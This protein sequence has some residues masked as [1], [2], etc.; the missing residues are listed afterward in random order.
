MSS[1][2][3]GGNVAVRFLLAHGEKLWMAGIAISAGLLIWSAI[4]HERLD[5]NSTPEDLQALVSSANTHIQKFRWDQAPEEKK[6]LASAVS[7]EAMKPIPP[8]Q[9]P[10]L[11]QK[12][13]PR[14]LAPVQQRTD[15]ELLPAIDLEAYGD[16]G[17][18]ATSTPESIAAK[19]R[20]EALEA[21][22][23]EKEN[24]RKRDDPLFS[25][26]SPAAAGR[27][28]VSGKEGVIIERP[29][30]GSQLQGYEDTKAESWVTVVA[31]IPIK[32]Q[33]LRYQNALANARGYVQAQDVPRYLGYYVQRS[34]VTNAGEGPWTT[35]AKVGDKTIQNELMKSA[36][37]TPSLINQKYI[38]P[39]LTYPLP[40]LLLR[41]WDKRITHSEIPLLIDEA[42]EDFDAES[43]AEDEM[44]SAD[45]DDP[46]GSPAFRPTRQR[47]SARGA[48]PSRP[49][50]RPMPGGEYRSEAG[51]Y[52]AEP[53]MGGGS[54]RG[55]R[56]RSVPSGRGS[57]ATGG[58]DD[59]DWDGTTQYLLF[60]YIDRSVEPGKRY[61]Y[62]IQ[63]ALADVN[64]GVEETHLDKAVIARL[65]TEKASARF[66]PESEPS[67]I[68]SVPLPARV[69]LAGGKPVKESNY[70]AEP[71]ADLLVKSYE[72]AA[73]AE[74]ALMLESVKRGRV[75]N[76]H[77]KATVIW[78][79]KFSADTKPE[80]YFRTGIALLDL[81]GG[82]ALSS[83]NRELTTP[84]RVVLM[85]AS[86]R[87]FIQSQIDDYEPV[88]AYRTIVDDAKSKRPSAGSG[89]NERGGGPGGRGGRRGPGR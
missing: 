75:V 60:R 41:D 46:F 62:K 21:D 68:V 34:E 12:F 10:P 40:S 37:R 82:E 71:V 27:D 17:I 19:R 76:L 85:D 14:V 45:E 6:L 88:A 63:L 22:L 31:K 43:L 38:H 58:L 42:V 16:S 35:I 66:S 47:R 59:Y 77:D 48:R 51:M 78:S 36:S 67:P 70:N 44:A 2:L 87:M 25:D 56:S 28:V 86:G 5:E 89:F 18:L 20:A 29:R 80:F 54:L 72:G 74:V 64:R 4:G 79:N 39:L 83:K 26:S 53:G 23:R 1:K 15:P 30:T 32:D 57:R 69:Y 13:D 55:G 8:E 24:K 52:G 7:S 49:R 73:A 11:T 65:K 50:G 84:V 61:R 33:N 81:L 9:F 3:K